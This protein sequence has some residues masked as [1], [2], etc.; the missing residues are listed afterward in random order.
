MS[1]TVNGSRYVM[2]EV[3]LVPRSLTSMNDK[4]HVMGQSANALHFEDSISTVIFDT[5][6]SIVYNHVE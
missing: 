1:K 4:C 5:L 3:I 2:V 6:H